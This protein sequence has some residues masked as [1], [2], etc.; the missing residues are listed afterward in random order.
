MPARGEGPG[1]LKDKQYSGN[2][3]DSAAFRR[4]YDDSIYILF[5]CKKYRTPVCDDLGTYNSEYTDTLYDS[6]A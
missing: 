3:M 6:Y 1:Y 2:N 5:L 4:S